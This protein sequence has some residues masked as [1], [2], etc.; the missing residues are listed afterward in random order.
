ME[1]LTAKERS[2]KGDSL[3]DYRPRRY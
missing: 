2:K 1:Q 3:N